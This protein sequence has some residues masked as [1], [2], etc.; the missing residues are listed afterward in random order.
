MGAPEGWLICVLPQ[1]GVSVDEPRDVYLL[2]TRLN[3]IARS[4]SASIVGS[5]MGTI[6]EAAELRQALFGSVDR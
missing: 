1:T 3:E 4:T 6:T 5:L 2:L